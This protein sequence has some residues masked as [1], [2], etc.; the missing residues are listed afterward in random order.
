MQA[1]ISGILAWVIL[2]LRHLICLMWKQNIRTTTASTHSIFLG[3]MMFTS[4]T[5][6][7]IFKD[8][9][10][11]LASLSYCASALCGNFSNISW[12]AAAWRLYFTGIKGIKGQFI[13]PRPYMYIHIAFLVWF[14]YWC[15]TQILWFVA[16]CGVFYVCRSE[17]MFF[18]M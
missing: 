18:H 11:V 2:L 16:A 15:V 9:A 3:I 14:C 17:S 5:H 6:T 10:K 1:G 13:C 4:L 8:L 12:G 7:F